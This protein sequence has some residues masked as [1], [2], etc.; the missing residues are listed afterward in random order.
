MM[1]ELHNMKPSSS[2]PPKVPTNGCGALE[3]DVNVL[4][5]Q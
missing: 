4:F 5:T 1:N 3:A 2:S